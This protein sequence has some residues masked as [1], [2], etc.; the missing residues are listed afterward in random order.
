MLTL[1][2][3]SLSILS[4][5]R[6]G[7][8]SIDLGAYKIGTTTVTA[9]VEQGPNP[10]TLGTTVKFGDDTYV[11]DHQ[12]RI[13]ARV[14]GGGT[15]KDVAERLN[16]A[17]SSPTGT[18]APWKIKVFLLTRS[19]L[20]ETHA[21]GLLR[22]RRGSLENRQM[23]RTVDALAI[24]SAMIE[25]TTDGAL[26]PEVEL[27]LD[28]EPTPENAIAGSTPYGKA[29]LTDY[30]DARV[31]GSGY[32]AE[33]RTYRGPY[34][35]VFVIHAGLVL[36]SARAVVND[37]PAW[38]IPYYSPDC[39][40]NAQDM[41]LY[42][43]RLWNRDVLSAL[44][45]HGYRNA[46]DADFLG[47][48]EALRLRGF[49]NT[50]TAAYLMPKGKWGK[51]SS[52]VE[53]TTSEY[54]EHIKPEFKSEG[55]S[56]ED[57]KDALIEHLPW[58]ANRNELSRLLS[59]SS[60]WPNDVGTK[61]YTQASFT[62]GQGND[63]FVFVDLPFA[64]F[65]GSHFPE[66]AHAKAIA[67]YGDPVY[68]R[69]Y[70]IFRTAATNPNL[71]E[72]STL[73]VP[74]FT[75]GPDVTPAAPQEI[76][77]IGNVS[78]SKEKDSQHGDVWRLDL[79]SNPWIARLD[80]VPAGQSI[81][82]SKNPFFKLDIR[83][84]EIQPWTI[85][86]YTQGSVKPAARIALYTAL[87]EPVETSGSDRIPVKYLPG[88]TRPDW[89]TVTID[90][91]QALDPTT[92]ARVTQIRLETDPRSSCIEPIRPASTV[93]IGK[94][95]LSSTGNATSLENPL[96][97]PEPNATSDDPNARLAYL[98]Q[99]RDWSQSTNQTNLLAMLDD[100]DDT[101]RMNACNVLTRVTLAG[102][103][104]KLA[105]A[106]RSI[107][108]RIAE[109]A[110]KALGFQNTAPAWLTLGNAL[111]AGPFEYTRAVAAKILA[112][113][114]DPKLAGTLSTLYVSRSWRVRKA[115]VEALQAIPGNEP[116]VAAM[117]F[118]QEDD[119]QVRLTVTKGADLS[120]DI[121]LRR[122]LWGSVNDASDVVRAWSYITLIKSGKESM[123]TE[124]YKGI[125]DDGRIVRILLLNYIQKNPSPAAK[126]ALKL[127]LTDADA[128][129][130]VA[131]LNAF[132]TAPNFSVNDVQSL[133]LDTDPRVKEAY[134]KLI[135][136]KGADQT[137]HSFAKN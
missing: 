57:V 48:D 65:F 4:V 6:A 38:S 28:A 120:L 39:G 129:V 58:I 34:D 77:V 99:T 61:P 71:P 11:V 1:A 102:S 91:R 56:W 110:A 47:A 90:L 73:K 122:L 41:A 31:N 20:L 5:G 44:S 60:A 45:K 74:G 78:A 98:L 137:P 67:L 97:L 53:P 14:R 16:K 95:M 87:S 43:M 121:V 30:L 36:D 130:R 25:S 3:A 125:R 113:R 115:G 126:E 85:G 10:E 107:N 93:W 19:D 118:L 40:G 106:L 92:L 12:G 62:L 109:V 132:A 72:I 133:S 100:S 18:A 89:Y 124:G 116:A 13:V 88:L 33:D 101:V 51:L 21:N 35:S 37:S 26:R 70:V 135:K 64:D 86:L 52:R 55:A 15:W 81:D 68:K 79:R 94:P 29:F 82:L 69:I 59:L 63:Q 2:L 76:P 114:K 27:Q 17:K 8:D 24:L 134:A 105:G 123:V 80:L 83:S 50:P 9:R 84:T 75:F 103:E 111:D 46:T 32:E 23:Q 128:E 127:A 119:P 108:T 104:Q 136:S 49:V 22:V 7:A 54:I 96:G 66:D 117:A 112:T 42:L 131:A